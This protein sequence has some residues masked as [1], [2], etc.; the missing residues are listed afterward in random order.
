MKIEQIEELFSFILYNSK[1][2][3]QDIIKLIY[4]LIEEIENDC[5][6]Y[7]DQFMKE[8]FE[9]LYKELYYGIFGDLIA[10]YDW[11]DDDLNSALSLRNKQIVDK[12]K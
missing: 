2:I 9:R 3:D 12:E 8:R 6:G 10:S 4:I 11:L 7:K 5:C 1:L